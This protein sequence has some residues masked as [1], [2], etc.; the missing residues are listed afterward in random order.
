M[1]ENKVFEFLVD[2]LRRKQVVVPVEDID[3]L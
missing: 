1:Q 2:V 3:F